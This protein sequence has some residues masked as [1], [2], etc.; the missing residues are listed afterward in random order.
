VKLNIGSGFSRGRY[1]SSEWV[2]FDLYQNES[3]NVQGDMFRLPFADNTFD[4]IH[5]IHVLE[6]LTRDKHLLAL[7]EILRVLSKTGN[8][9]VEVP[10]FKEIVCRLTKAWDVGAKEEIHKWRTSIFGKTERPGMAH[11]MG[12]DY[13]MLAGLHEE[14]GFKDITGLTNKEDM[15]SG[16]YRQEPVLLIRGNK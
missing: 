12:F 2:N 14:A 7:Q 4:E 16:H 11:H 13:D 9:Y 1:K 6:H 15:I 8:S 5:C 10:D 3:V